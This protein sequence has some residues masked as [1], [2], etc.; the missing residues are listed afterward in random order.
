MSRAELRDAGYVVVEDLA[1]AVEVDLGD[2]V[3]AALEADGW[4]RG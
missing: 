2:V 1:E 4:E 3:E